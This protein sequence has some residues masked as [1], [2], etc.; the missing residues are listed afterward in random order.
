MILYGQEPPSQTQTIAQGMYRRQRS[1]MHFKEPP[2]DFRPCLEDLQRAM[3][4]PGTLIESQHE[5]CHPQRTPRQPAM[6]GLVAPQ[7]PGL[8]ASCQNHRLAK[9]QSEALARDGV[10]GSGGVADERHVASPHARE[11]TIPRERA[12]FGR[13]CLGA[14]QP[15]LQP[16]QRAESFLD[17]QTGI[18]RSQ[19]HADL[20]A[21]HRCGIALTAIAPVDLHMIAPRSHAIVP[22]KCVTETRLP[23]MIIQMIK[24]GPAPHAGIRAIR[25]HN[26]ARANHAFVYT[27]AYAIAKMNSF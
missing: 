16:G 6:L 22:S 4:Q 3:L 25:A 9:C 11:S 17:P 27:T 18:M 5:P 2:K 7:V 21:A 23:P 24:T 14:S 26:P 20:L 13:H 15:L 12:S 8:E 10:N 19:R 1:H